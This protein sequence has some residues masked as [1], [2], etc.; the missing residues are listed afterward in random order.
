M[1]RIHFGR[2]FGIISLVGIST[3]TL[4]GCGSSSGTIGFAAGSSRTAGNA[5]NQQ[6][7]AAQPADGSTA[8]VG[9][10]TAPT[11]T[12]TG[13]TGAVN[14]NPAGTS[15]ANT[16]KAAGG[17]NWVLTAP[18]SIFGFPQIQPSASLLDQVRSNLAQHSAAIG[19][20]GTQ[21]VAVYDDPTHD[22]YLIF[23]GYNGSGYDPARGEAAYEKLPDYASDGTGEHYVNNDVTIDP[24]PHGGSAGCNST[25]IQFSGLATEATVCSWMT[26][27]TL[28]SISYY[29]KPDHQQMVFG[30]G[31]EVMGKVMRD[32]R[33]LV[34]HQAS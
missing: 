30:T 29:P 10:I 14:S 11:E 6:N 4:A 27:T 15:A 17:G 28:G 20:T 22:V 26:T 31:P 34:E 7:T 12:G 9:G 19:V 21:V 18:K 2:F 23:A 5:G 1:T 16:D 33:N 3:A 32:L 8:P 25:T 24:G 13:N